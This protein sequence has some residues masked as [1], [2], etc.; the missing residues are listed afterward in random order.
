MKKA[1]LVCISFCVSLLT[2]AAHPELYL[3]EKSLP[4][5]RSKIQNSPWAAEAF[6]GIRKEIDLYLEKT[7]KEPDWLTSRLAMY[8]KDGERYTQCYLNKRQNWE[9]GEG[10]A[11]VPTVRL[12]G[13]R[14][15]NNWKLVPLEQREPYN[16]TGD[17][18]AYDRRNPELPPQK[19]PYKESGH[20][21]RYNNSEILEIAEKAAFLYRVT[22]DERCAKLA[23]DVFWTWLFGTYYMNPVLDPEKS[24]GGPGGYEPGGIMG[25]YD[26]EQIHDGLQRHGAAIYDLAFD[27]LERNPHPHLKETGKS[28]KEVAGVVF[29]RFIDIGFVRGGKAGNWNINGWAMML[30]SIIVLESNDFYPDGKGREHY[31]KYFTDV[32]TEYHNALPDILSQYDP[33]TG[34]WPESPCYALGTVASLL[35][36]ATLLQPLGIDLLKKNPI[37]RKAADAALVWQDERGNHMAFGDARGGPVDQS[38]FEMLLTYCIRTNDKEGALRCAAAIKALGG[39][40]KCA[41]WRALCTM[42]AELPDADPPPRNRIAYSPFHR[43]LL[44]ANPA[45]KGFGLMATLYGGRKGW[46][47]NRNG[48]AWQ[49]YADGYAVGPDAAAY[50]SYWTKDY[51]YHQGPT[52]VNTILPGYVS[53]PIVL[54]AS[55][56]RLKPDDFAVAEGICPFITFAD[57]SASEKRRVAALI[58]SGSE[59]GYYVDVFRSRQ[60]RNDYLQHVVGKWDFCSAPTEPVDSIEPKFDGCYSYFTNIRSGATDDDIEAAWNVSSKIRVRMWMAGERNAAVYVMEAPPT[61]LIPECVPEKASLSPATTPAMIVRREGDGWKRPFVAVYSADG[62]ERKFTKLL[63]EKAEFA[64]VKVRTPSL[65]DRTEIILSGATDDGFSPEK[66]TYAEGRFVAICHDADG[67]RYLFLGGAEEAAWNGY[68]LKTAGEWINA[69]LWR[70]NGEIRYSADGPVLIGLPGKGKKEYPA[71]R[72]CI[73][74]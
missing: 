55:E 51:K 63:S 50:E 66:G 35:D 13:M 57:V 61:T 42:A 62:V 14:I 9:R 52:G 18:L 16:E 26:Y 34:L 30:P 25:Y 67:L 6:D 71:G 60:D 40:R 1:L 56:P 20:L 10:N 37:L 68:S 22:G 53:G 3:S 49:F 2:S 43:H 24:T 28:L 33:T 48:L 64:G 54:N 58:R 74:R 72:N 39:E 5:V 59:T 8:W 32:T 65:N 21:V 23:A 44:L 7:R 38:V 69:V 73:V 47:L 46:H 27:Y 11:P 29:K 70:E 4:E 36:F 31:L 12:P 45:E 15:W 41:G 17:I 19:V